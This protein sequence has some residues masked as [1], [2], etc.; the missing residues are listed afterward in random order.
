[1]AVLPATTGNCLIS[2]QFAYCFITLLAVFPNKSR[3]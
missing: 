2:E 3:I 1:M